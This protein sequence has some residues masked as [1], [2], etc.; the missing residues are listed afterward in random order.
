MPQSIKIDFVSD[1]S[2]PWC[3]VGLGGLELAL[4]RLADLVT[5]DIHFQPFELNPD[6]PAAGENI[7]EHIGKKYGSTP[8]QSAANRAAIR[9]RAATVGFEMKTDENSRIYNTFDAHRLLHWAGL[10]GHQTALKHAL[11]KAHFTDGQAVN[12]A[13][14]LVT[15]AKSA[16]LDDAEAREVLAHGRYAQDVRDAEEKWRL[17]GINSVPA[18]IIN[19]RYLISGGQPPEYFEQALRQIASEA[20]AA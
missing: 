10:N 9:E 8:A 3:V 5:A 1:V 12:D 2:C 15:A 16:G 19:D 20:A 17:A 7:V 13:D 4:D 6:M 11:F 14:V 18:V